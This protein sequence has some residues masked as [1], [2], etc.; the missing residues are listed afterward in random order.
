MMKT[1]RD[2]FAE[3]VQEWGSGIH[4]R[5]RTELSSY[6]KERPVC[7]WGAESVG[8]LYY[9]YLE[10]ADIKVSAFVDS[11][12][13]GEILGLPIVSP[14]ELREHYSNAVVFIAAQKAYSAIYTSLQG[15]GFDESQIFQI[16]PFVNSFS[17]DEFRKYIDGYEWAY[18]FYKDEQSKQIVLGR[19]R[20]YLWG[21]FAPATTRIPGWYFEDIP[22]SED[23]VFVDAG[24]LDGGTTVDF[25]KAVNGKFKHV[26]AFEPAPHWVDFASNR[27]SDESRVEVIP[28][29]L[30]EK[31]DILH[32][33]ENDSG[34]S[35]S[36]E[37]D[38]G[39]GR[40]EILLPTTSL[41]SFFFADPAKHSP[42]LI[43]MN[44]E[45]SEK[46]ALNGGK[47]TIA[48][49]TPKMLVHI[50]HKPE[51]IYELPMLINS[52]NDNYNYFIS[53]LWGNRG[54]ACSFWY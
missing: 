9:W 24:V 4:Q 39:T 34:G 43:K 47:K 23:E 44:I 15:L 52:I 32:F 5:E 50:N 21:E 8:N 49:F 10:K 37:I 25:I 29:G 14:D 7:I 42:T 27:F 54:G 46:A 41:D 6:L 53:Q 20:G 18:D 48:K 22:L 35:A 51:D 1:F 36:F 17:L 11:F 45:G 33:F 19:I 12:H 40:G 28:K 3:I 13:K 31:D 38:D 2:E 26:Y 16:T 30:H